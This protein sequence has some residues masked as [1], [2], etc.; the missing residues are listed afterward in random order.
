MKWDEW[1]KADG[2]E[3]VKK[4]AVG[5]I[6]PYRPMFD[7]NEVGDAH[8]PDVVDEDDDLIDITVDFLSEGSVMMNV[9]IDER[10]TIHLS[11]LENED[12]DARISQDIELLDG[13]YELNDPDSISKFHKDLYK[14]VKGF[15]KKITDNLEDKLHWYKNQLK[16]FENGHPLSDTGKKR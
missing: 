12:P 14:F 6:T 11:I 9:S 7:D 4:L 5:L 13:K 16:E 10:G 15:Y 8:E 3:D 2:K 1:L